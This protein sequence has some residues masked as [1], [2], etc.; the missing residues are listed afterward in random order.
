M[1]KNW[2]HLRGFELLS[3]QKRDRARDWCRLD[4]KTI[5]VQDIFNI[6]LCDLSI[7]FMKA[8]KA[9]STSVLEHPE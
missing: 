9:F 2:A 6:F 8:G 4:F 5:L 7:D 3:V 1:P